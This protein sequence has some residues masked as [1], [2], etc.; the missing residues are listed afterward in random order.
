MTVNP[1]RPVF[2]PDG[3]SLRATEVLDRASPTQTS[4]AL[5]RFEFEAGRGN[6][7]T[8][9]LMVEWED[10]AYT[11]RTPGQWQVSW[12]RKTSTVLPAKDQLRH[13]THRL[14]FLLMPGMPIPPVVTL[15]HK[16]ATAATQKQQ[17]PPATASQSANETEQSPRTTTT[18]QINP[19]PAIFP[20]EL[21]ASARAQGK[22]GV[23]HTLWGKKRLVELQREI[24]TETQMNPEGVALTMALQEKEWIEHNFG[25]VARPAGATPAAAGSMAGVGEDAPASPLT[26]TGPTSPKTPGGSSRLAE[27]LKGLRVGTSERELSGR[28]GMD[29]PS[30]GIMMQG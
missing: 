26:P 29:G 25:L 7:G 6:N 30:T 10:N 5:A 21:G 8:K 24:E 23:L 13:G 3:G 11:R 20:P 12:E 16:P 27:R 1:S 22:K 9:I 18:W 17:Q 19:L 15:I 2:E 4:M 28:Q 14:Y